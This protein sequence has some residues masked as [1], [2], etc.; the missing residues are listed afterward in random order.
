MSES[1]RYMAISPQS[2]LYTR[3]QQEAAFYLL[4]LTLLDFGLTIPSSQSEEFQERIRNRP[5]IYSNPSLLASLERQVDEEFQ[6][7]VETFIEGY[8]EVFSSESNIKD[9]ITQ[10]NA[11]VERA[12]CLD[13]YSK[14]EHYDK[15]AT[16]LSTELSRREGRDMRSVV[17]SIMWGDQTF[18]PNLA[19]DRFPLNLISVEWVQEGAKLLQEISPETLFS[20]TGGLE[21]WYLEMFEA[22]RSMYL[23]A[24]K[25]QEAII[26]GIIGA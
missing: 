22:W 9:W 23:A 18:E 5:E 4:L 2:V 8:P 6:D 17:D 3:L 19:P 15:I 11:E 13:R 20:R 16:R 10:F 12:G 24:A 21:D 7:L 1:A 14:L 25:H 26:V